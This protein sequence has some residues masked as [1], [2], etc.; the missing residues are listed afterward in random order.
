M[1]LTA[2]STVVTI[3]VTISLIRSMI[4]GSLFSSMDPG[5][6]AGQGYASMYSYIMELFMNSPTYSLY[7]VFNSVFRFAIIV[8]S[9]IDI[10][11]VRQKGYS[12]LGL[13]LFTIFCKPGYFLWRAYVTKQKK[14]LPLLFTIFYVLL[15]VGYFFWCFYFIMSSIA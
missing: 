9:V 14:L 7:S 15:Y 4:D 1:A 6:M 2:V 3:L 8:I 12:I 5:S 13:V 10:V 11:L